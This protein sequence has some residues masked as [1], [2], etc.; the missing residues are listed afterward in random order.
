MEAFLLLHPKRCKIVFVSFTKEFGLEKCAKLTPKGVL[1]YEKLL[2]SAADLFLKSGFEKASMQEIVNLSGGSLSTIYKIFG[3]KEGLF[4]AVLEF[5]TTKLFEDLDQRGIDDEEDLESFL[6]IVG[7]RFLD[8]TTSDDAVL[9]HRLIVSE[10]F[11]NDAKL[12][13]LFAESAIGDFAKR[14]A[15][16]LKIAQD[17]GLIEVEDILLA[18]HQFIHALKDPFLFRRV[19]GVP[20]EISEEIKE[21]ALRQLVRIFTKGCAKQ[22]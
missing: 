14:I 9:F 11:R 15:T 18:S 19:L 16:H 12:G 6:L 4:R 7:K 10:G 17:K 13:R 22:S 21:K 3:N 2:N 20:V 5:K 1:R 8:L